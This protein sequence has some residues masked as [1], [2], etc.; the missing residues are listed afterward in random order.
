MINLIHDINVKGKDNVKLKG[1]DDEHKYESN[2][3]LKPFTAAV[4]FK[5][6]LNYGAGSRIGDLT[7][8]ACPRFF[9]LHDSQ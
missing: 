5:L 6:K 9:L 8:T 2:A 3:L 7:R 1:K 4:T